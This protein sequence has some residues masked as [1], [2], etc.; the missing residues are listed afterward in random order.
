[1]QLLYKQTTKEKQR[2]ILFESLLQGAAAAIFLTFEGGSQLVLVS[3]V[4]M[5]LLQLISVSLKTGRPRER[6]QVV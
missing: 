6:E 1:M 5:P 4:L 2:S 3:A